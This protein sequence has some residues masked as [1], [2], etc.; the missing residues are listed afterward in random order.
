MGTSAVEAAAES[1]NGWGEGPT[2]TVA[3]LTKSD[4]HGENTWTGTG[5]P[6]PGDLRYLVYRKSVRYLILVLS[7]NTGDWPYVW[8][9][10]F[11]NIFFPSIVWKMFTAGFTVTLKLV[12]GPFTVYFRLCDRLFLRLPSA[13][14]ATY[15]LSGHHYPPTLTIFNFLN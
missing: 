13:F 10:N 8:S 14:P 15:S 9:P 4:P 11:Q 1:I 2:N 7:R 5:T 3:H 12:R 6:G